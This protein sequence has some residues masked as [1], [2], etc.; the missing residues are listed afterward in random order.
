MPDINPSFRP[1]DRAVASFTRPKGAKNATS[2]AMTNPQNRLTNYFSAAPRA[3]R[4]APDKPEERVVEEIEVQ[5]KFHVMVGGGKRTLT[6]EHDLAKQ[7]IL[8]KQVAARITHSKFF[9][10]S[11]ATPDIPTPQGPEASLPQEIISLVE[12]DEVVTQEP[13]YLSPQGSVAELIDVSSPPSSPDASDVED[14]G[15]LADDSSDDDVENIPS[16]QRPARQ[17]TRYAMDLTLMPALSQRLSPPIPT[18]RSP[19]P[20][21]VVRRHSAEVLPLEDGTNVLNS[22]ATSEGSSQSTSTSTDVPSASS[23]TPSFIVTPLAKFVYAPPT[24]AVD[25]NNPSPSTPPRQGASS[26]SQT[27]ISDSSWGPDLQDIFSPTRSEAESMSS[28]IPSP[29]R[30]RSQSKGKARGTFDDQDDDDVDVYLTPRKGKKTAEDHPDEISDDGDDDEVYFV[31][32]RTASERKASVEAKWREKWAFPGPSAMKRKTDAISPRSEPQTK[33][34][35][36]GNNQRE[37]S[38]SPPERPRNQDSV[39][40]R[41]KPRT[42]L[43][44]P[45]NASQT[46]RKPIPRRNATSFPAPTIGTKKKASGEDSAT[47]KTLDLDSFRH[48]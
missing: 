32:Q 43:P 3:Q 34:F 39:R 21:R 48:Q 2:V 23:L 17:F 31:G 8:D 44:F 42:S 1:E 4:G 30:S 45:I 26:Q 29:E 5:S 13:G 40:P 15:S 33:R 6:A 36:H 14:S 41:Q 20:K 12:D 19:T 7:I 18:P 9:A 27:S 11:Q 28:D 47:N 24:E 25:D 35:T 46:L 16:P 22:Q 37:T 38:P 10:I